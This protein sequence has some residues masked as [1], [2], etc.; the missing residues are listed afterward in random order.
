MGKPKSSVDS[1]SPPLAVLDLFPYNSR[2]SFPLVFF[3]HCFHRKTFWILISLLLGSQSESPPRCSGM[4]LGQSCLLS[5]FLVARSTCPS[6]II[7]SDHAKNKSRT[8]KFP[9]SD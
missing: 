9:V 7:I 1:G 3:R 2:F 8:V 5:T 6:I 4:N